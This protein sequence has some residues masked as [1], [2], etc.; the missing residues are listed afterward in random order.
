MR[1]V[2]GRNIV[3]SAVPF[4]RCAVAA[5]IRSSDGVSGRAGAVNPSCKIFSG[6]AG[7]LTLAKSETPGFGGRAGGR[8]ETWAWVGMEGS[9][10]GEL[11]YC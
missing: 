6:R 7:A 2:E 4:S 5:N 11:E 1:N 9:K 3:R 10:A 8:F